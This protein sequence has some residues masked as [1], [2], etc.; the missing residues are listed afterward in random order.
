ME[1]HMYKNISKEFQNFEIF[2]EHKVECK[3]YIT[4]IPVRGCHC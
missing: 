4:K 3:T 1:Q 2:I